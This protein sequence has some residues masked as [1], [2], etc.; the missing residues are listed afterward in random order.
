MRENAIQIQCE[1]VSENKAIPQ[2][3][4]L[5]VTRYP[6]WLAKIAPDFRTVKINKVY[7]VAVI[8]LRQNKVTVNS[9]ELM[10]VFDKDPEK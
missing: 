6:T 8:R 10:I 3:K 5:I 2:T 9:V 1:W 7:A 4:P